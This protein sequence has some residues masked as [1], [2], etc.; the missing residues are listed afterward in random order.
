[1]S[2][3]AFALIPLAIRLGFVFSPF[4]DARALTLG[5]TDL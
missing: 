1:V 4:D 5:T 2:A 3:T